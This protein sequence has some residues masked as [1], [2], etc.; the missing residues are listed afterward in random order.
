LLA[1][2]V[3]LVANRPTFIGVVVASLVSVLSVGLPYR[4]GLLVAMV[5]G[6]AAAVAADRLTPPAADRAG[7]DARPQNPPGNPH[8]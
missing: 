3:P 8:E 5:L 6:I 7:S 2:T 1:I 4:L